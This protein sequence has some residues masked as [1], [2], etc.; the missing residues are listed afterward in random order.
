MAIFNHLSVGELEI[1]GKNIG[2]GITVKA[3]D[4]SGYYTQ[5][6]GAAL[7]TG[8]GYAVGAKFTKTGTA[9]GEYTNVGTTAAARFVNSAQ[10]A[11]T[12]WAISEAGQKTTT[13]G[14]ATTET[15]TTKSTI[16]SSDLVVLG[17]S[18]T[19]DTDALNSVSIAT[20]DTISALCSADPSTAHGFDYCVIRPGGIQ[21]FGVVKA[22]LFT[23]AGGDATESITATG[24]LATDLCLVNVK[25]LG[26]GSRFVAGAVCAA[27]AI[28]VTMSGDP[29]ANHVLNYC[30]LRPL[31]A[32]TPS[33]DIIAAGRTTSV[34]GDATET[35]VATGAAAT[36][37]AFAVISTTDDT[38]T[39]A[40]I[41]ASAA[42][43]LTIVSSADPLVAHAYDW[44]VL[45][46]R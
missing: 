44:F 11:S 5:A 34:G 15:V 16:S 38:D 29:A 1:S 21:R 46:A 43:V 4:G 14:G 12:G 41:S 33:H 9:A 7:P 28:T 17:Y 30:V 6:S 20:P 10:V 35:I 24:A 26:T 22:G 13:A 36:D 31:G 32:F 25:T 39:I 8:A 42:N 19:N 3:S 40:T 2:S 45:R 27:N 23:T 37:P 18:K